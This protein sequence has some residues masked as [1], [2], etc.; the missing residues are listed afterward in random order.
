MSSTIVTVSQLCRYVKSLLEEQ[1]PLSDLLVKGEISNLS[2]RSASGH[3][4][5]SLCD[6]GALLKCVMFSRYAEK[7]SAFPTDGSMAVVRGTAS[8]YERDGSFQL[9]VYDLQELG[10]GGG[11]KSFEELKKRLYSE[12]L[13]NPERKR[14]FPAFPKAVGIITSPDGAALQDIIATFGSLNP[15]VRL[16][17]YPATVQ[18]ATATASVIAALDTLQ[19]EQLCDSCVIARGGGAAED[20][21]AFNDETLARAAAACAIPLVSA[22]GHEVDYSILDMVADA[23]AATP[24]AACRLLTRPL[25]QLC[26]TITDHGGALNR[27]LVRRLGV[28]QN[29]VERL[30]M[31]LVSKSPQNKIEK[32]RQTLDFLVKSLVSTQRSRLERL[33]SKTANNIERL[34]LVNPAQLLLRGYSITTQNGSVI[35]SAKQLKVGDSIVTRL[36]DGKVTSAVTEI[37]VKEGMQ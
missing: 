7:L 13:F 4:Y 34:E 5:F 26:D 31:Q 30:S 25:S 19:R 16:I 9:V 15:M 18:G 24:T 21:S 12:G 22:V 32:N 11:H 29:R 23:R 33:Y 10:T 35:T 14:P 6:D 17:V 28:Y 20:L 2:Y 27:A 37:S 36:P 3:L 8:L 1:K